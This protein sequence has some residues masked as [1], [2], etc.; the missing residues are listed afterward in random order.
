MG[1]GLTTGFERFNGG[2]LSRAWP[3]PSYIPLVTKLCPDN[4]IS[5]F[6]FILRR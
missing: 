2:K 1:A 3:G 6:S 4:Q 5:L